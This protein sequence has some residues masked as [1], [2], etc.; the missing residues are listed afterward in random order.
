AKHPHQLIRPTA[1]RAR[2]ALFNIIGTEVAKATVLDLYA[3]TGA[4]GLE[5]LSRSADRAVFVDN[6]PQALKI[7]KKNIAIC[8]FAEKALVLKRD[9]SK[10]LDFL[11]KKLPGLTFS[12]IFVD[13]PYRQ[14]LS[15]GMLQKLAESDLPAPG[16]LIVVEDDAAA[17]LP[18][19]VAELSLADQ[20]H[21]GE[22]GFWFYR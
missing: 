4:L 2:E 13:P 19:Q 21:Y 14:G 18:H 5:A 11:A 22:T 9:I 1:D 8:G 6:N 10:S 17:E 7:I 15:A 12:I 16:A 3:G 20:R